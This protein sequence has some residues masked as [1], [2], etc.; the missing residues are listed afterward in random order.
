MD[1]IRAAWYLASIKSGYADT[2]R[3]EQFVPKL[4]Y[5]YNLERKKLVINFEN[6]DVGQIATNLME[7]LSFE[8]KEL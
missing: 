2:Y 1:W 4:D 3:N 6:P 8:L 7:T 5:I